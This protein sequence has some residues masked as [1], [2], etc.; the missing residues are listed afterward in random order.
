MLYVLMT[1]G[2]E[3]FGVDSTYIVEVVPAVHLLAPTQGNPTMVCGEVNYHGK[4]IPV[5]DGALLLLGQ[6][7]LRSLSTRILIIDIPDEKQSSMLGLLAEG[8]TETVKSLIEEASEF[9]E[10]E[11][12]GTNIEI[13]QERASE[14]GFRILNP[15][16]VRKVALLR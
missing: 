1:I 11:Y 3:R 16:Y 14:R 12:R 2:E 15:R 9:R 7:S 8:M 13:A 4:R 10:E 5:I 6:P